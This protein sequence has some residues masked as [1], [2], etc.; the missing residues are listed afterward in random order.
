MTHAVRSFGMLALGLATGTW[1]LLRRPL[2][3]TSGTL[4]IGDLLDDVEIIRDRWGVP[5][6]YADTAHDLF[7]AQGFVHAQ[8]RFWQMDFQRRLVAGRLSEV[9]GSTT[10]EIDRWMRVL[11][12]RRQVEAD[13]QTVSDEARRV[14]EAYAKGVNRFLE[15]TPALPMEFTLLHYQPEP[16]MPVDSLS[17]AKMMAFGLSENWTTEIIRALIIGRIGPDRASRLDGVY[18][19]ENPVIVPDVE[20]AGLGESALK[21]QARADAFAGDLGASN[22]WV[23]SGKRSATG[24]PL[25][26][27][28][29]HLLMRIPGIWYEN[30][31]VGAGYNVTG[32]SLPGVPAVIIGHNERIA[33]GLTAGLAD[34]Q[35]LYIERFHP[36][37]PH[38]YRVNGEWQPAQILQEE[39]SVRGR[40]RPV[41]E[42]VVV[43]H[44]GPII[45]DLA[46]QES[47]PLA[48][49]WSGYEPDAGSTDCFLKL[50]RATNWEDVLEALED[51]SVPVLNVTYADID[52]NIGYQFAGKIPIR[53]SGD[54]LTPVPGW[55]DEYK[56]EGYLPLEELPRSF[57]PDSGYIVTANNK[58]AGDDYPHNLGR[59][60]RPG[61]RA[62]RIAELIGART[63]HD[64]A[65]FETIQVDLL[66]IPMQR[67]ARRVARLQLDDP[68]LRSAQADLAYWDG[69]MDKDAVGATLA[70]TT[71]VHFRRALFAE[72]L[73]PV[74]EYY[75]GRGFQPLLQ[76]ISGTAAQNVEVA[77]AT[78]DRPE[79]TGVTE[80]PLDELLASNFKAAV[81]QL[82]QALGPNM[83]TWRWGA[84]NRLHLVHP[85]GIVRPL[86]RLLNR[87][88]YPAGGDPFTV[89][90]NAIRI[91]P[92]YD[93]FH[94][95]S[96]RM[97]VDLA[98]LDA[99]VSVC[100][101]GQSGHPA[102][103]HYA[104]QLADWQAGRYHAMLWHR[105]AV[106]AAAEGTLHLR[107]APRSSA[108]G[109]DTESAPPTLSLGSLLATIRRLSRQV[110][111]EASE[112]PRL[113][114]EL[115]YDKPKL[116]Y[117]YTVFWVKQT[118]EWNADKRQAVADALAWVLNSP[119]FAA[120]PTERRYMVAGLEGQYSGL[121]LTALG[122]VLR[123]WT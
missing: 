4:D 68:Q 31:L 122:R 33:W 61:F 40:R 15:T 26:A 54:G 53:R 49:R 84:V 57:N 72:E 105:E 117:A 22:S 96:Y 76:P 97:I 83:S 30:H 21:R 47:Q 32:A 2:P 106:T 66:S 75:L 59:G 11:G 79:E 98:D 35:D 123:A 7:F 114:A 74:A 86:G 101:T 90:P 52:G 29:P 28:D 65:S 95:A 87:G 88:P 103:P 111:G 38:L 107:R 17:W 92:Y 91:Q 27:S 14:L 93:D 94:S 24:K 8:D 43:T 99:S 82:K 46:P 62:R 118:R 18:P 112:K 34:V 121:S 77:L 119:D 69:V 41:V 64:R 36:S 109:L 51:H 120:N 50:N 42:E 10:L 100:P 25:L 67:L 37:Y 3:Q 110:M 55:T 102:S 116:E 104:D 115:D 44:H 63:H 39:I 58:P 19:P 13:L 71:M 80:R 81:A 16:W 5:H 60:W 20:Y 89:W 113:P 78:L 6:I 85:L 70:Y 48:L 23:V 9:L 1:H 108:I 12:L 45:T 73:G 56:W